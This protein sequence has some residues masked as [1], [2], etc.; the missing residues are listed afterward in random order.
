ME[1]IS[2]Y[3]KMVMELVSMIKKINKSYF[4]SY[5]WRNQKVNREVKHSTV[6]CGWFIYLISIKPSVIIQAII[7]DCF[8]F[9]SIH[10]DAFYIVIKG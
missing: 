7:S 9:H 2:F 3:F 8:F 4:Q 1:I 6:F 5:E 10:I